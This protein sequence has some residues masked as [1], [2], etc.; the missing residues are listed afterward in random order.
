MRKWIATDGPLAW[1][2]RSQADGPH[3]KGANVV[4]TDSEKP[5]AVNEPMLTTG[6]A[7][8]YIGFGV[9]RKQIDAMIA[10]REI[11]YVRLKR[12]AWAR[13]PESAARAKRAELELKLAQSEAQVRA[14]Q[15]LKK[16]PDD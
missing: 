3:E 1:A 16:G 11:A 8:E 2:P 12:G 10:N 6:E 15:R 7:A 14:H 9:T 13:I 4:M 5:P